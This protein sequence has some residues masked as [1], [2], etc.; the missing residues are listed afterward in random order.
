LAKL[1]YILDYLRYCTLAGLF[2][3]ALAASEHHGQVKFG[4]LPLPG[5]TVSATANGKTFTAI[6]DPLGVYAFPDLPDG[7]W[8]IQVDMLCF[9]TIKQEVT[10]A[11]AAP[12]AVWELK[13]LPIS[14]MNAVASTAEPVAPARPPEVTRT[15]KSKS[16]PPPAN[17]PGGFQRTDVNASATPSAADSSPAPTEASTDLAQ[18]PTDGLLINGSGNN[19][20]SSPFAL[21]PAFGNNRKGQRSQYNGNLGV[22]LD[23]SALDARSF[24]LTG[25]DT[26]KPAYNHLT[27]LLS[28]G[29]PFRI[30][31]LLQNGP[32][33]T[34]NYQWTRNRSALTQSGL[35]PTPAERSGDLSQSQ[36]LP[37]FDPA[38]GL[39]FPGNVIPPSR[40]SPQAKA[41][42]NFY[43]LP[44]FDG[45]ARYNYQ[46]PVVGVTHQDTLQTRSNKTINSKN[47]VSGTFAY[48]SIRGDSPNLFGF[49]DKSGTTGINTTLNW[50]HTFAPRFFGN[51]GY[52]FSRLTVRTTANFENRENVSGEAGITGNNQE[53]VNWGPP[54]LSFSGGIAGLSDVPSSF[55][56][57][58]TNGV[59]VDFYVNHGSHNLRFGGD[60]RRQQFNYLSQ[61]DARGTF[62]FTGASTQGSDFAGF[63]LGIPD[64][65]SI[66]FGNADKYLRASVYDTYFTDDWRISPGL[67]LNA[68]VRWEYGSPIT[69]LYGRLVNL[70]IAPGFTA[71]APVVASNPTGPL[72]GQK[73]PDSLA[74]PD[75]GGFEPRIGMSWRPL[76]ASS[77][78]VR[79]GYGVYYNT[80]VYQ[81]I[82]IQMAQQS[83]LSKSLSVQNSA[84]NPLT[85]ANGFNASP[86]ITPNTFA[87][88]PNFRVG[89]AQNWQVSVQQDLPGA[90]VVT[91]TY[92]GI[93]GTRGMQEFLPNTYPTGA[94]NP[95]GYAY[96]TSNGNSTRESGQ[97]QV[98]RRLHN[99]FTATALY[100]LSKS[101]DDSAL[102]GKGQ[103]G[104]VIAQNWLDLSAE[105]G[106]SNFDQRHL[107]TLQM[108]Y[109]TGMGIRGGTLLSGWKGALFKD[110]TFVSQVTAGSGLPLTPIYLA[111]V[112]GTGVT[113][114][115]RPDYTGADLYAASGGAFLNR[116]A[117]TAPASGQW[118]NAG[119]NSITGPAQLTVLASMGRTFRVGD[120]LSADLR[121]DSS[122]PL[123][124][125]TFP[126]WNTTVTSAQ[127]G[128]PMTANAMRS[129]QTS[130]RVRF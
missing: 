79:G 123:N 69:E 66:A 106:L 68:G 90:L 65:S 27:G 42:L 99:G 58:E 95:A 40:I 88:N 5:A 67:T 44:N 49:L 119:R 92:L 35:M 29:G 108:Q 7:T 128:L 121:I 75:K 13:L 117:Y 82:A 72:T 31:H 43:P 96:L 39:P 122:N 38:S 28:F 51:F 104:N 1:S 24:S 84:N 11:P 87:M 4:G 107:L 100:T 15:R 103:A 63:L 2:V 120:R 91:G 112:Q 32:N 70:D 78:V 10:V 86:S 59:S 37:V 60:F 12:A 6:T 22:I 110:W 57:N 113:G 105:R 130:L 47:Q 16:T 126:S 55:N 50:R 101:I 54:S 114:S 33:F 102:G 25:Q 74:R 115:I 80:S 30:P 21:A 18:K 61:Q 20:A 71:V 41:L 73:Y 94:L 81:S 45:R 109:S 3:S 52:Q 9:A 34:L 111:A 46:I 53:A 116:N 56:R 26:P 48:Q 127:F 62:T 76:P 23:N 8:T 36:S 19:G 125:V 77:M 124:H 93:K 89:Y 83:P 129:V 85:L 14:E 64:T 97:L 17:T 98:R 118:G